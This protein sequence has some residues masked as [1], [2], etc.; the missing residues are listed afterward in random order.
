MTETMHK[1]L[2]KTPPGLVRGDPS[3][4]ESS[5]DAGGGPAKVH[6]PWPSEA[7]VYAPQD[8]RGN[9]SSTEG[10]Q[11]L[12]AGG[13]GGGA[14]AGNVTPLA[15]STPAKGVGKS[16]VGKR[17]SLDKKLRKK[18]IVNFLTHLLFFPLPL[19]AILSSPLTS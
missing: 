8:V 12:A 4:P 16:Q 14:E 18:F 6:V 2:A 11:Q 15:T 13:G 17:C 1:G 10:A 5:S 3:S 19:A 7:S 9:S